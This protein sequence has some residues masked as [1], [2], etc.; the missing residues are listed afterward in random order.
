MFSVAW[1][2]V[3]PISM[4]FIISGRFWLVAWQ[5][6]LS[7][8]E[9]KNVRTVPGADCQPIDRSLKTQ[10]CIL[11]DSVSQYLSANHLSPRL[12]PWLTDWKKNVFPKR[13]YQTRTTRE[14]G[15][16]ALFLL[17]R[18]NISARKDLRNDTSV[19]LVSFMC[20]RNMSSLVIYFHTNF[21]TS[22]CQKIRI[23]ITWRV[24]SVANIN[25]PEHKFI[26]CMF[27]H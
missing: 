12:R 13:R 5:A 6:F 19:I 27:K 3:S 10:L 26:L 4:L 23:R 16:F 9:L 24:R 2:P 21:I 14:A 22:A 15:S 17:L 20:R 1:L 25:L 8:Q 18:P 7:L 11:G